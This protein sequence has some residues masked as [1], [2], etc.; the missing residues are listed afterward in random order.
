MAAPVV[1]IFNSND[2]VVEML[3]YAIE[4]AGLIVVSA[5]IDAFRR[6]DA[7]LRDL[8][9]EHDP[10]VI[11]YDI[12][13]P[14]DRNWRFFEHLRDSYGSDRRFVLTSTN[15]KRVAETAGV[16]EPV[17]EILGKPYDI[18][19]IV[20]AVKNAAGSGARQRES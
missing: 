2:D 6:A 9:D 10:R 19:A 13:P 7:S 14:Y 16:Q 20:Q 8:L 18:D 11:V 4:A 12:G 1:A 3:R 17:I 5:H 15:P